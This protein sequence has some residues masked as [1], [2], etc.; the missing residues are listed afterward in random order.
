[1]FSSCLIGSIN[2]YSIPLGSQRAMVM[3]Y[4]NLLMKIMLENTFVL[5]I[6]NTPSHPLLVNTHEFVQQGIIVPIISLFLY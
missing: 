2:I 4:Q 3:L 6:I 5:N 1:M